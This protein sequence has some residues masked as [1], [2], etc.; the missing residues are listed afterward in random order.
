MENI[1][2]RDVLTLI[3][4]KMGWY[5]EEDMETLT[6]DVTD[7]FGEK[8]FSLK[9]K[10]VDYVHS[11]KYKGNLCEII[12]EKYRINDN[13]WVEL[14][15]EVLYDDD[16]GNEKTTLNSLVYYRMLSGDRENI[17]LIENE[18]FSRLLKILNCRDKKMEEYEEKIED[19]VSFI[20]M[21]RY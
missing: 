16:Y 18:K 7:M 17:K 5:Y 15:L 14:S 21:I 20:D 9:F 19:K 6:I 13:E 1:L 10:K 12:V 2:L 11:I 3:G 8:Q 4:V